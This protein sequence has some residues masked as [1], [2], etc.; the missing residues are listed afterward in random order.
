[1]RVWSQ[2]PDLM[3]TG[4]LHPEHVTTHLGALDRA[5]VMVREHM[6]GEATKTIVVE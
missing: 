4:D 1:M 2:E 5:D 3:S 6:L